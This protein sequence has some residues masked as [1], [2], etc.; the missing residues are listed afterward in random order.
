MTPEKRPS[1]QH[2]V[3]TYIEGD[4]FGWQ[5]FTPS[6]RMEATGFEDFEAAEAAADEHVVA[7]RKGSS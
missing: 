6:C 1:R 3:E 2:Y 7:S 4:L 5:C